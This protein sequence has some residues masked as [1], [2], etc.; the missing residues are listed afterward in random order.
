[1]RL[2][3]ELKIILGAALFAFIPVCVV[4]GNEL[5]VFALLF[6]RLFIASFILLLFENNKKKLFKLSKKQFLILFGWSQLM[7]GSM[8]C[9][10]FA[11][12]YSNISVS[13]TLLGTQP[14]VI[15][16]LAAI[17]LKERISMK[18]ILVTF[19]TLIGI[20]CITGIKDLGNHTFFIGEL[21]AICAAFFLGFNFILQKKYLIEY[22]GKQLA[23]YQ[24][25]FQLP[26]LIPFLFYSPGNLTL[27]TISAIVI[28]AVV[29][30]VL[31]YTLIYD[32]IRKVEAQKIGVLQSV[33]YVLPI[34]LGITFY[35]ETPTV[36][37]II[38]M[39]LI[40]ISCIFVS[41]QSK[42]S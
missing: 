10:F 5:S 39:I 11:I 26:F 27:N 16:I 41:L 28:L 2:S 34:L 31:A 38:G 40:I 4:L 19:I 15:V 8:I 13:S 33:E 37:N 36:A 24:G 9:Y 1:M 20:L 3:G 42:K 14:V 29:C 23:F 17:L 30:T 18:N 22:N 6:G 21:L 32:G 35:H 7:L 25:V 12:K